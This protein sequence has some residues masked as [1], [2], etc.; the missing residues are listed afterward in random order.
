MHIPARD[1][2]DG[3]FGEGSYDKEIKAIKEEFPGAVI[4]DRPGD[5]HSFTAGK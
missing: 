2:P 5:S 3:F 1:A 4:F